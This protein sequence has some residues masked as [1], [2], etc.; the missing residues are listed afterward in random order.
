M[1]G[2]EKKILLSYYSRSGNAKV[3]AQKIAKVLNCDIDEVSDLKRREGF[4]N[5][6]IKSPIESFLKIKTKISYKID[7][8]R[9]KMIIF[10]S[11]VWAN[12]LSPATR[13]YVLKNKEKIK[14]YA[15]FLTC[16]NDK[17]NFEK[18]L[19]DFKRMIGKEP[20]AIA[21]FTENEIKNKKLD[22]K[23]KEFVKKVKN[24]A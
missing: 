18:I 22:K 4:F 5:T 8:S 3:I 16:A 14:N 17:N 20:I 21:V 1:K 11:P 9:Y 7:P 19:I 12:N 6:I 24:D 2:K 13:T 15:F 10:G 23:I